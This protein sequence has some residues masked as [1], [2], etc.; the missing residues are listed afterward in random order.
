MVYNQDC[1]LVSPK[2]PHSA[3]RIASDA[4]SQRMGYHSKVNDIPMTNTELF[5]P[6]SAIS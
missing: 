2:V 1:S 6:E 3:R 4:A 5:M